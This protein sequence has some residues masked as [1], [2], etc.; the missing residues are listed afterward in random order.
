M[1]VTLPMLPMTMFL[2]AGVPE[3]V[4]EMPARTI[5][6]PIEEG[7]ELISPCNFSG[8][9]VVE[10]FFVPT[11][12]ELSLAEDATARLLETREDEYEEIA[13]RLTASARAFA[14]PYDRSTYHRQFIGYVSQG[15]RMIYGSFI[16]TFVVEHL[17]ERREK[18]FYTRALIP[19]D[20]G[21]S[22][23]GIEYDIAADQTTRILFSNG[24][25][26]GLP[27]I[28]APE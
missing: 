16:P 2:A 17:G 10:S 12:E 18:R 6:L 13:A 21:A 23:F 7:A 1:S 8:P 9:D 27:P 3:N 14:W 25:G 19:C 4:G 20:M 26:R 28:I 24:W 11:A 22:L 15:R 5:A